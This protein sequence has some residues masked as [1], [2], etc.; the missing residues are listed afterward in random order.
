LPG[1]GAAPG[2]GRLK[3]EF[4][5]TRIEMYRDT[6]CCIVVGTAP[7]RTRRASGVAERESNPIGLVIDYQ[8]RNHA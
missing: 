4:T 6:R 1:P 2:P 5:R 7:R 8:W 3:P